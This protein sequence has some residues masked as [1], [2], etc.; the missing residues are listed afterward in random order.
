MNTL[1][2]GDKI[3]PTGCCPHNMTH[4]TLEVMKQYEDGSFLLATLAGVAIKGRFSMAE[5]E[6]YGYEVVYP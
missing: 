4:E 2:A 6:A 3:A 1:Q 5:L